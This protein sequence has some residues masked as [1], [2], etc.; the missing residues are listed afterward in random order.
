MVGSSR[1]NTSK[2]ASRIA[3][4][5][6]RAACPPDIAG[7][8]AS[9]RSTGRP[10]RV[11]DRG[12]SPVEVGGAEGEVVLERGSV[13][14]VRTGDAGT[15]RV[16]C[17][18]EG[19]HGLGHARATREEGAQR[20]VRPPIG[21]LREEAD[22]RGRWQARDRTAVGRVVTGEDAQ[23]RAL[24]GSVRRHD[25]DPTARRHGEGHAVE[26]DTRAE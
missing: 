13:G 16:R 3:A 17:R 25:A 1:R 15:E 26:D 19:A 24:P 7:M 20:L 21:F 4:S 12:G 18:V 22:R 11:D 8:G 10:T 5:D 23:E 6:A 9:S 14:V 2:R